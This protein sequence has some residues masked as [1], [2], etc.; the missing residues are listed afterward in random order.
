V[1]DS[2]VETGIKLSQTKLDLIYFTGREATAKL[3]S[4]EASST[5]TQMILQTEGRMLVVIDACCNMP[6]AVNK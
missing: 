6:V 2:S 4:L 3:I 5:L 1:A